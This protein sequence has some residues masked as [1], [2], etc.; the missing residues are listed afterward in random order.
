LAQ[1]LG[2]TDYLN[3]KCTDFWKILLIVSLSVKRQ[4]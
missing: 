1:I 3:C 4:F 2:F